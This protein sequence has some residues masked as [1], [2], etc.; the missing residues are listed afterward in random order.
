MNLSNILSNSTLASKPT[1]FYYKNY[2]GVVFL[3]NFFLNRILLLQL[4]FTFFTPNYL[5]RNR[6]WVGH[7]TI[8][9][10]WFQKFQ[11]ILS[12]ANVHRH[13]HCGSIINITLLPFSYNTCITLHRSRNNE[14]Y[15]NSTRRNTKRMGADAISECAGLTLRVFLIPLVIHV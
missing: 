8:Q 3:R 12:T 9:N 10:I 11:P 15:L 2:V 6:L 5:L 14:F 7:K 1:K 13:L 4:G